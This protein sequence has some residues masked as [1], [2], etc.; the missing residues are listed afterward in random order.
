MNRKESHLPSAE[1]G[2]TNCF[3]MS[4]SSTTGTGTVLQGY[5]HAGIIYS[6]KLFITHTQ[7]VTSSAQNNVAHTLNYN[8]RNHIG[9]TYNIA[10]KGRNL[11]PR[12]IAVDSQP[13]V[14]KIKIII[15]LP[16]T[17]E[18]PSFCVTQQPVWLSD[19][20]FYTCLLLLFSATPVQARK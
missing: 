19:V 3:R 4:K 15:P 9:R 7:V 13:L 1:H 16:K 14:N 8:P 10:I 18:S 12:T 5:F 11:M 2:L 6:S 20:D 17:A